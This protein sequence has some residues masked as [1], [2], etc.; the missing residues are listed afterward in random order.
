MTLKSK[1][2]EFFGYD[3]D[4]QEYNDHVGKFFH[5]KELLNEDKEI[6]ERYNKTGTEIQKSIQRIPPLEKIKLFYYLLIY[7]KRFQ[8][9]VITS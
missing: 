3:I 1:I 8:R 2:T 6:I 7:Y 5:N 9:F 4:M